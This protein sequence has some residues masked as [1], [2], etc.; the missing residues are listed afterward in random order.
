V[1][2]GYR[3]LDRGGALLVDL[4]KFLNCGGSQRV[5]C[6]ILDASSACGRREVISDLLDIVGARLGEAGVSSEIGIR[7]LSVVLEVHLSGCCR[8]L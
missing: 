3:A 7:D 5:Q 8:A 1:L 4:A 6:A 2:E